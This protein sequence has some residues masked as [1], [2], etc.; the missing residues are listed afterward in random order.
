MSCRLIHS[1]F[2]HSS[3]RWGGWALS[4]G[5]VEGPG[6]SWASLIQSFTTPVLGIAP[7]LHMAKLGQILVEPKGAS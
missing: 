5:P 4:W 1:S 7:A 6:V 2:Q 3:F